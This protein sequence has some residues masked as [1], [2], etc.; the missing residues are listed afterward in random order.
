[1]KKP[2]WPSS[3]GHGCRLWA[4]SSAVVCLLVAVQA[5]AQGA[6]PAPPP[7]GTPAPQGTPAPGTSP[8]P[9]RPSLWERISLDVDVGVPKLATDEFKAIGDA[10]AGFAHDSFG[11]IAHGSLFYYSMD[12][13]NAS[14]DTTRADYGGEAWYVTGRPEDRVGFELR[15][16]GGGLYYESDFLPKVASAGYY[17]NEDSWMGRG[18]LM[19]GV[20]ARPASTLLT[21][22]LVGGGFLYES[23]GYFKVDPKDPSIF[24]DTTNMSFRGDARLLAHWRFL[25]DIVSTRLRA[26]G[27]MF[28]LTRETESYTLGDKAKA[29]ESSSLRQIEFRARLSV[30]LDAAAF[31]GILP[32]VFGGLDY[33]GASAN[34]SSSSITIPSAGIGLNKPVW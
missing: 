26:E 29:A 19:A 22:A 16:I 20:K 3:L 14:V 12:K 30:E 32:F 5:D 8:S 17:H 25:P 33:I 4:G 13:A 1:M 15:L 10:T 7:P 21:E 31:V 11:V 24:S 6:P 34:G 23:Y 9:K 18:T 28:Q 27:A 2:F